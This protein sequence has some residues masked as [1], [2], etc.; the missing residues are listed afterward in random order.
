MEI[1]DSGRKVGVV[2]SGGGAKGAFEVGVLKALESRGI[3]PD[4]YCGTSVGSFNA[5]MA[6]GGKTPAQIEAVWA[7]LTT[8]DVFLPRFDP[9]DLFS[10]DPRIQFKLALQSAKSLGALLS[11]TVRQS[12]KWWQ[13]LDLDDFLLD[14]SPLRSL[15]ERN[16]DIAAVRR[17][18]SALRIALTRLKPSQG[19][20]L[21]VV[22]GGATTH[23]QIV[24]STA[25]PLIFPPVEIDGSVYCD[26]GVVMNSPLKPAIHA[27]AEDIFVVDVT[28]P[29][30]TYETGTL[31]LAYHVLSAQFSSALRRDI[32]F[33]QDLNARYMAAFHEGRLCEGRL[34]VRA[35]HMQVP[36]SREIEVAHY[37]Y[38]RIFVISPPADLG[39]LKGF[40]RFEPENTRRLIADG[41]RSTHHTLD[42][43]GEAEINGPGDSRLKVLVSYP[44]S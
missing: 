9:L 37:K 2:L 23:R 26:G 42:H 41:E 44:A 24:A 38:L 33:A 34:E 6:A 39:G 5:A 8:R 27:G 19:D 28:P 25:I 35:M 3:R 7:G 20:A 22:D 31:P 40:L 1:R 43:L 13:A 11:Q 29:P 18:T 15:I 32:Q 10:P 21:Q 14:T 12:G 17:S 16:V 36:G 4:V 30:A